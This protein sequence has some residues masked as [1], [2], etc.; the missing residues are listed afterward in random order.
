MV[1]GDLILA[2]KGQRL[3]EHYSFYAAFKTPDEVAVYHGSEKIGMLPSDAIPGLG[4]HVILAGKRW[5]V[6]RN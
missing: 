3:V 5:Q 6:V 1:E 2:P 4:E